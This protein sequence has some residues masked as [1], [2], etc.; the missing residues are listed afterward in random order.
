MAGEVNRLTEGGA[1]AGLVRTE[2][3]RAQWLAHSQGHDR[4]DIL[5]GLLLMDRW[6]Q[7]HGWSDL[8]SLKVKS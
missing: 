7:Q 1:L 5:W 6:M 8:A 3:I 2:F 4:S